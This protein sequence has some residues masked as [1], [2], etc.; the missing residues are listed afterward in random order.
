[1]SN[2]EL[3]KLLLIQSCEKWLRRRYRNHRMHFQ[4]LLYLSDLINWIFSPVYV[5]LKRITRPFIKWILRRTTGLCELQRTCYCEP[6]G[7][8]R[9]IGI[10]LSSF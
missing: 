8:L 10:G 3:L 9:V 4:P 6:G 7:A 5:F 1:M 2:V